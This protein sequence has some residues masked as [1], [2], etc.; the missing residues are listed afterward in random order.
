MSDLVING[1]I[2]GADL[3]KRSGPRYV[4]RKLVIIGDD[5][6]KKLLENVHAFGSVGRAL[7]TGAMGRF[8]ITENYLGM[9]QLFGVCLNGG[10]CRFSQLGSAENLLFWLIFMGFLCGLAA[11]Q[12]VSLAVVGVAVGLVCLVPFFLLRFK[13]E[14]MR[15]RFEC[16]YLRDRGLSVEMLS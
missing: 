4:Y 3:K 6:E 15:K 9:N 10:L 1:R 16:D 7:K 2:V 13:R 8:Y 14:Q 12:G 5:G 11:W